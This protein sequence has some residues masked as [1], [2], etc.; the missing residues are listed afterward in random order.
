MRET[1]THLAGGHVFCPASRADMDIQSCFSCGRLRV[2][3]DEASPP[4]IVC[5]T[6][7]VQPDATDRRAYEEWRHRHH[8]TAR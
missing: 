3:A 5:D 4:F 2:L 8:R 6:S 7:D 1:K